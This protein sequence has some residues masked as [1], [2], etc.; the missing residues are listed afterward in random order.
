MLIITRTVVITAAS[1]TAVLKHPKFEK[2][3]QYFWQYGDRECSYWMI[4][5]AASASS[6]ILR[7]SI[8]KVLTSTL[9]NNGTTP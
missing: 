4:Y 6:N 3:K 7:I 2:K 8:K 5:S 1:V 9:E